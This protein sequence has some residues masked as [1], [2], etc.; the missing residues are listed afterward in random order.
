VPARRSPVP[1]ELLSRPF[2]VAEALDLGVSRAVL[3][4]PRF[5]TPAR[6]VRASTG[7]PDSLEQ[8]CLAVSVLRP[9]VVFSHG[10]AAALCELP[11][12]ARLQVVEVTAVGG[13]RLDDVRGHRSD[14]GDD[15]RTLP[16]GLRVTSGARTWADHGVRLGLDD[17]VILG[18]AVLRHGW[19]DQAALTAAAAAPGRRGAVRLRT[20]LGLLEPRTDSPMETR[21]RLLVVRSGLPRPDAGRDVVVD[22]CW[23]ARPDLSWPDLRIAVEYDGDHHRTDR[24]QWQRDIARRRL[25]EDAGWALVVV[26][27]DDVLRHPDLLVARLR[28]LVEQRSR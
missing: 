15:V 5:R 27:A 25:L 9:G 11:V 17:L 13:C 6:G 23:L 3:R 20:A 2:T 28:R 21:L 18:D 7:L 24:T 22:G 16:N 1:A 12:P 19:A 8:R 14:P 4:R 26:T 10:A